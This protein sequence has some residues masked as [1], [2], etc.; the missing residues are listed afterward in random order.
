MP[1]KVCEY[2]ECGKE[3]FAHHSYNRFCCFEHG[4]EN[5]RKPRLEGDCEYC[6]KHFVSKRTSTDWHYT[7]GGYK[8]K[9]CTR[10][11]AL[12]AQRKDKVKRI[13]KVCGVEFYVFPSVVKNGGGNTHSRECYHKYYSGERHPNW[14][15]G[16]TNEN[17]L[18]RKRGGLKN[19]R[20]LILVRDNYSCVECG[21]Q[22]V[23]L[24]IDHI[25]SWAL[26]PELR[27]ELDNGRT[28][29]AECHGKTPTWGSRKIKREDFLK[30]GKH[31][32]YIMDALYMIGVKDPLA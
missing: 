15:G 18:K 24:E 30:G 32:D 1:V 6:G 5:R 14:N 4:I 23:Q 22:Y 3:F 12:L 17:A 27:L 19:W 2:K 29:C 28:L 7:K 11:H 31:F 20:N 13:C 25:Y 26:F 21:K 16:I 10:E 8:L 9:Y